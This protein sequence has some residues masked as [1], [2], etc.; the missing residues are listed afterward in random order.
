VGV[1]FAGGF[2]ETHQAVSFFGRPTKRADECVYR[3]LVFVGEIIGA[4]IPELLADI[5]RPEARPLS[6]KGYR[7]VLSR[8]NQVLVF[9]Q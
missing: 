1:G 6:P 2:S 5:G 4:S 8:A 7:F 3:R 9:M